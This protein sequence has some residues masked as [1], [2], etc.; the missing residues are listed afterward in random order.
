[1]TLLSQSRD[2]SMQQAEKSIVEAKEI[3]L[4]SIT[5]AMGKGI[6]DVNPFIQLLH[7]TSYIVDM[8]II[9]TAVIN[10]EKKKKMDVYERDVII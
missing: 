9:P 3:L 5:F 8:H 6:N 4:K 1:M 2:H 10:A 7:E